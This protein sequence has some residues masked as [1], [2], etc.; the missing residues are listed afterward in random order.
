MSR[1]GYILED[2]WYLDHVVGAPVTTG[3][4]MLLRAHLELSSDAKARA[5]AMERVGGAML[6]VGLQEVAANDFSL[7]ADHI[8]A[9]DEARSGPAAQMPDE[10]GPVTGDMPD[11]F[12]QVLQDFIA[13]T[14]RPIRW[15]FLGPG[16][17]KA[18]LWT[19]DCD[20]RL[21]LL[22]ARPGVSIP[23]HGHAGTELTLVLQGSFLDG[24]QRFCRGD[25]EEASP[26]VE[27]DILIGEGEECICLALTEGKL[28]FKET[29]P[30]L[31]QLFTGL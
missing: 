23:A 10:P 2:S 25:V 8:F 1:R 20:D 3:Q 29:V 28:R 14:G 4:D 11:C 24:E 6:E 16:L 21:W 13:Q 12:P 15:E 7:S 31:F 17:K 9:L 18:M 22:R 26:E 19:G 5:E 27:H 30:R